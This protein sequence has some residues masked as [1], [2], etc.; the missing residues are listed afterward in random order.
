M[1]NC[2]H[3]ILFLVVQKILAWF[4][5]DHSLHCNHWMHFTKRLWEKVPTTTR[6][7]LLLIHKT[8]PVFFFFQKELRQ[9][10]FIWYGHATTKKV[11]HKV[12]EK[13]CRWAKCAP[14][15]G[16]SV[17][18]SGAPLRALS[19]RSDFVVLSS[20]WAS[21]NRT[22]PVSLQPRGFVTEDS[23]VKT[24]RGKLSVEMTDQ[25]FVTKWTICLQTKYY[26]FCP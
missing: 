17:G 9:F 18:A 15:D 14:S 13:E 12:D 24:K 19:S 16:N 26:F 23:S 3:L 5:M 10:L 20:A 21:R 7:I 4:E 2:R 11:S 1:T 22:F 25:P 6:Q 8:R